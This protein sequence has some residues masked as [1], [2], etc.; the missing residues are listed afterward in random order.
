AV[1]DTS[2]LWADVVAQGSRHSLKASSADNRFD[3]D[4]TGWL[5]SLETGL[6]FNITQGLVLEPQLQ[7]VW[8]RLALDEGHDNGGYVNFGD[9]SAQHV[10]AG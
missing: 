10:R 8:Q 5:A 4:G 1:H 6:P 2:G 3:T 7:Y 9:G